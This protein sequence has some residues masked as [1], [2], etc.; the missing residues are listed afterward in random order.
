MKAALMLAPREVSVQEVPDP[1]VGPGEVP[2]RVRAAD[3]KASYGSIK[4]VLKP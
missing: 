3:D 4:V 2:L 1:K